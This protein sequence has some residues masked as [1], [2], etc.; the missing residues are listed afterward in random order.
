MPDRWSREG[1]L[2]VPPEEFGVAAFAVLLHALA[3]VDRP[4]V[5]LPTGR[6]PV[7]LYEEM[8]RESFVFPEG[9]RLF[10]ID[11]YCWREPHPGTNAAFFARHLPGVPI[12]V[13]RHDAPHPDAEIA[14]FCRA[15]ADAGGLDVA[16]VGIGADGHIAFNEPGSTT[17]SPCRVTLLAEPTRAQ[18]AGDWQPQP[19]HGMTLGLAELL[20]ARRIVLLASGESKAAILATAL[21]GP[22]TPDVPASFLQGHPALTVVCDSAAASQL[23]PC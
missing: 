23:R 7:A 13:P 17:D 21:D 20:R 10:A 5:G 22:V 12:R 11:E 1:L 2:A 8:Q 4:V 18:I 14:E 6:T 15:V 9:S 16:V 19:T 3:R